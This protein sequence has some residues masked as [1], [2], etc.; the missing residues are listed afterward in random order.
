MGAALGIGAAPGH[1]VV[2]LGTS[3]TAYAVS[4]EPT[5]DPTGEVCGFADATGRFMPLACMLNCTRVVDDVARLTG[6]SLMETLDLAGEIEPGAG[7]LLMMPY[8]GGERTPNLPR[9][10]GSLL[11]ITAAN[12]DG[13]QI[14]RAAVDGVA[15]GLAYCLAALRR[16]AI[17][18][19]EIV[20]VGGGSAHAT[21]QQAIA[22]ATQLDVTVRGGRE[23]VALGAAMQ[24]ASVVTGVPVIEISDRWKPD[25]ISIVTPRPDVAGQFRLEERHALIDAER[26]RDAISPSA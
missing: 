13:G 4:D 1:Y 12:L 14:A 9:A 21:W 8:L 22:D 2:S 17:D 7:G 19:P 15:A 3:G 26:A 6:R 10:T 11:G 16:V 24:A 5:A 20:L 23:H 18:E 25:P